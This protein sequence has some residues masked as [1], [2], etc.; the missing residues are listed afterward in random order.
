MIDRTEDPAR[1]PLSVAT[2]LT[3]EINGGTADVESTGQRLFVRFRSIPDAIRAARGRPDRS[4]IGIA[5]LLT[6]TDL[7]LE[8]RVRDRT[9]TAVGAGARPGTVSRFLG[10]DP[11][12]VR[13]GGVL[14]AVGAEVSAAVETVSR[15][16]D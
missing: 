14:G 6:V 16:L 10:V 13:I 5:E 12:E 9:V 3:L 2:D 1:A 7:T 11:F 8:V 4:A 15:L